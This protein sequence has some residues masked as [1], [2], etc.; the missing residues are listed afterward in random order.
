MSPQFAHVIAALV[1]AAG[2][3]GLQG[4]E[5]SQAQATHGVET[6]AYL[7]NHKDKAMSKSDKSKSRRTL[8]SMSAASS[9]PLKK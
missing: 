8:E 4:G 7:E 1:L 2:A 3:G 5:S 9:R 6:A